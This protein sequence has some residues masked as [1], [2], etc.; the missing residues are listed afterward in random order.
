MNMQPVNSSNISHVGYDHERGVLG[1]QFKGGG[2]YHYHGITPQHYS[3]F[4]S[5]PS[6]G[7]HLH[8]NI[9]PA[10]TKVEKI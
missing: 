3:A 5:A 2:L 7:S 10:A 4:L 9:K 1:V 6:L 8:T